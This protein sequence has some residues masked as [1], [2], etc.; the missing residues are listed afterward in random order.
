MN[1]SVNPARM[2]LI[3]CTLQNRFV[4]DPKYNRLALLERINHFAAICRAA[5]ILVIHT[6]HVV[7]RWQQYR[8]PRRD[9]SAH[10]RAF[11]P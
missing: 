6:R 2:A 1:F 11:Q 7:R 5:D 4:E 9:L 8:R 10:E 3:N